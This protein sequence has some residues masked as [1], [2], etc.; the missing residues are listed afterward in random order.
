VLRHVCRS[1][2]RHTEDAEDASQ[3]TFLMLAR[4]AGSI[5]RGGSVGGWLSTVAY[6][7]ALRART[8]SARRSNRQRPLQEVPDDHPGGDPAD[9]M[10]SRELGRLLASELSR[11][12]EPFR[13]AF[14]LCQ[15]RR[16]AGPAGPCTEAADEP[17]SRLQCYYASLG[18]QSRQ[19][20]PI[21]I[22]PSKSRRRERWPA[23]PSW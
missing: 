3:A 20:S 15:T 12:P 18:C 5:S 19:Q 7:I 16:P 1:V 11:I 9:R 2:L 4:K 17:A 13:A 23:K 8:R 21:R 10:A 6:R 14:V 22:A